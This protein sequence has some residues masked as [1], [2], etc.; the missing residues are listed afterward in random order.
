MT[1][2]PRTQLSVPLPSGRVLTGASFGPPEGRPV[3]FVAGAATGKSMSFGDDCLERLGIRLLT[4][5]R[6]GMGGSSPDPDRTVASTAEDYRAFVSAAI[7]DE[8]PVVAVVANSQGALFGLAIAAAGW[9]SSLVLVSPADEIAHPVIHDMLPPQA[10]QLADMVRD[11]PEAARKMLSSFTPEAMEEMVLS[12]SGEEDRAFYSAA[13][14]LA[15]Y[16]TAL[17]EGFA[18][19][20]A[21][22][23]QDTLMAMRTWPIDPTSV[24]CPVRILFG[25]KDRTHSPDLGATLTSRFPS[26]TRDVIVGAGGALLWTHSAHI[27]SS[28]LPH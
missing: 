20:A 27:L 6:P 26:A 14:F 12:G 28:L 16:R 15:R 21:G 1:S 17:E 23:V 22:Y 13:P 8:S 25:E 3:L 24:T 9:A 11:A 2:N 18:N 5:D 10:T 7:R 19:G 4:M